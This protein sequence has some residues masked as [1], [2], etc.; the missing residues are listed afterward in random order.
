MGVVIPVGYALVRMRFTLSGSTRAIN[1]VYGVRPGDPFDDANAVA[2]RVADNW[3][4][5]ASGFSQQANTVTLVGIDTKY[6]RAGTIEIGS[7]TASRAGARSEACNSINTAGLL[8]KQTGIAGRRNRGRFFFPGIPEGF[9]D[10]AGKLDTAYKAS[11]QAAVNTW[12][13]LHQ[14]NSTEMNVLH[15]EPPAPAPPPTVVNGLQVQDIAATQR[16]RMRG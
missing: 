1:M 10:P 9:V 2:D 16:R 12:F 13:G 3:E 5:A 4:S 11:L 8:T 14:T 7:R 6:N 15:A